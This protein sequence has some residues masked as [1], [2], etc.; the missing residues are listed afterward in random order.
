VSFQGK[1]LRSFNL[2][3][4]ELSRLKD[5]PFQLTW[6]AAADGQERTQTL[7]QAPIVFKDEIN[8]EHSSLALGVRPWLPTQADMLR[9]D[10]VTVTLGVGAALSKAATVVPENIGKMVMVLGGLLTRKVST[11]ALGG[12]VMLYQL[13]SRSA[14][15]GLDYFL[16][17]MA[18]IS[19]NLGVMNLLP[20]PIL[21][22]FHLLSAFWEGIRRRPI[23]MRVR[24]LA[25]VV[26]L[27]LLVALMG[28]AFYNDIYRLVSR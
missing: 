16:E 2:L 24:E 15:L 13:A 20:I 12:P 28:M 18:L 8:Q 6:R 25:N 9:E 19:I 22:G 4:A 27:V 23:P 5:Q 11:D 7:A 26:G 10:K 21:D 1:P 14:D 3:M 17:L